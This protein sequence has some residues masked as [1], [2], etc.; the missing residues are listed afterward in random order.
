MLRMPL[1]K[2]M[3]AVSVT[4]T[5]ISAAIVINPPSELLRIREVNDDGCCIE[6]NCK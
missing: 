5:N 2:P 1:L 4:L 3:M 6:S